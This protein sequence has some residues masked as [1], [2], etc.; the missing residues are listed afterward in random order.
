MP[1]NLAF[2]AKKNLVTMAHKLAF[3]GKEKHLVPMPHKLAFIGKEKSDPY[4]T[5]ACIHRQKK[6]S[7]SYAIHRQKKNL[8][9]MPH[10]V[11]VT[12]FSPF[13]FFYCISKQ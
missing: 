9:Q 6:K 1:Y 4:A 10:N 8:I 3:I 7:D 2:I 12:I 5:L 13:I 11:A